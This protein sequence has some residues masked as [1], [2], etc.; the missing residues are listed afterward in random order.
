MPLNTLEEYLQAMA[1][2]KAEE[3]SNDETSLTE[4]LGLR[5]IIQEALWNMIANY[6]VDKRFRLM[7]E[8]HAH[9]DNELLNV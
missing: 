8:E 6:V 5:D 1:L 7:L 4:L 9:E 3:Y 2:S